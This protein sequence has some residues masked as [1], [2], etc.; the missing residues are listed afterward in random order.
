MLYYACILMIY[1]YL[2][3]LNFY[4]FYQYYIK[5]LLLNNQNKQILIVNFNLYIFNVIAVIVLF[6]VV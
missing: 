3:K 4:Y 2:W 1:L 5:A 6:I